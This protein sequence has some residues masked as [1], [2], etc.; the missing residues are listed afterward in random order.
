ME[1]VERSPK[2]GSV[3]PRRELPALSRVP[4]MPAWHPVPQAR[5]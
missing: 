1:R 3:V 2:T 5:R 4:D